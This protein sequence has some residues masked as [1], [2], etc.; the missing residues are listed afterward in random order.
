MACIDPEG[1]LSW[2][3]RRILTAIQNPAKLEEVAQQTD[4]P[5]YRLR[6]G[7]REMIGAGLAEEKNETY[8]ITTKGRS[9]LEVQ[10]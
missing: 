7:L 4:L 1:R 9:L 2:A 10:R 3:G 5:R 6:S 8:V